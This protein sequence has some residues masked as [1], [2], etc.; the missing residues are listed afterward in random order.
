V[1]FMN[2][3]RF[4]VLVV[5][6]LV[7]NFA[8]A[9]P[10]YGQATANPT[11]VTIRGFH[12]VS[13]TEGWVWT[14]H[15][16]WTKD[17]GKT[18]TD[19]TPPNLNG[20]QMWA[21]AFVDNQFGAVVLATRIDAGQLPITYGIDQTRDGGKT[22]TMRPIS[23]FPEGNLAEANPGEVSLQ[24][25]DTNTAWLRI[26]QMSGSAVDTGTLF[27]STD[28]GATWT[29]L[30]LPILAMLPVG[31]PVYFVTDQLGW[32][33]GYPQVDG[34]L[35]RTQ[36]GGQTWQT[37]TVG[38][39]ARGTL[40]RTYQLPQF[41]NNQ[42]GL[43]TATLLDQ[44]GLNSN[45]EVYITHDSGVSWQLDS[46]LDGN[47]PVRLIDSTHW[48][49][50][51]RS[52]KAVSRTTT[53]ADAPS[54]L[55]QDPVVTHII[56][57]DFVSTSTALALSDY[58]VCPTPATPA[59]CVKQNQL[60]YT[61]N[62]GQTWRLLAMPKTNSNPLSSTT[63]QMQGF[64][65]AC[66][67]TLSQMQDWRS[68]SQYSSVGIYLTGLYAYSFCNAVNT[69]LTV[70][71]VLL[72][73][74]QLIQHDQPG[75]GWAF[76]PIWFGPQGGNYGRAPLIG[77]GPPNYD[78]K[79]ARQQGIDAANYAAD[80]AV[81]LG[82][83]GSVIYYDLE[84][85]ANT[86]YRPPAQA[87]IAG[88]S[89]QL[90]ARGFKAGVYGS[91]YS[92]W[93]GDLVN[94]SSAPD[95]VWIAEYNCQH[96]CTYDPNAK[97]INVGITSNPPLQVGNPP[98]WL[99]WPTH[100]RIHQYAADYPITYGSTNLTIDSNV[101][102]SVVAFQVVT[103]GVPTIISPVNGAVLP[104]TTTTVTFVIQAGTPTYVGV[105]NWWLQVATDQNFT[106]I[107]YGATAKWSTS[108]SIR[109]SSVLNTGT[110]YYA[111][112]LQGDG[113]LG[114]TTYSPVVTL[115]IAP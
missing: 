69:N 102:D 101:M 22:W 29:K 5:I 55:S 74:Q 41:I 82:L 34:H 18:W 32:I 38:I 95:V 56:D 11:P 52:Q 71:N 77:G 3:L 68:N 81:L 42:D 115:S 59:Q 79:A 104:N 27:K 65:I 110:T 97:V 33:A 78:L 106:N 31:E 93:I 20:M 21:V 40:L 108:S 49:G 51:I 107:V 19:I 16:Y 113:L 25:L 92:S 94:I 13:L 4:I 58:Q 103:P 62:G 53:Q 100:Q 23:L 2:K 88:W 46:T 99:A 83:G 28:G 39:V 64:D 35:Y 70:T 57:M 98:T 24:F 44:N 1:I 73:S 66:L 105:M 30:N 63:S 7:A 114:G 43:L 87:L 112:A 54:I 91:A 9:T 12:L 96:T 37:Q 8:H 26:K 15:L 90:R 76:M 36:D 72:L 85:Y 60:L 111:R 48:I 67:P 75:P 6:L 14:D 109:V 80:A 45:L 47:G 10:S 17:A 50:V 89:S 61:S 86:S 84:P